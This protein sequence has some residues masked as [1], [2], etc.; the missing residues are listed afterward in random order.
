MTDRYLSTV[1][2]EAEQIV[3]HHEQVAHSTENV[4][5]E[6]LR[7]AVLKLLEDGPSGPDSTLPRVDDV[8]V[9]YGQDT[10]MFESWRTDVEWWTTVPPQ[11]ECTRFRIFYPTSCW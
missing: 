2:E 1:L 4:A 9:G 3:T 7:Y 10:A 11:E 5:H 6:Y 8:T